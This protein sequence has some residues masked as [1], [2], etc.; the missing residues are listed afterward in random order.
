MFIKKS[1]VISI[2]TL[3]F[4]LIS[5]QAL[6]AESTGS[7]IFFSA[8]PLFLLVALTI[9]FRKKIFVET[10]IDSQEEN[11]Q[12]IT[13]QK[14]P[15]PV[16]KTTSAPKKSPTPAK[17]TTKPKETASTKQ[18]KAKSS[19][20]NND[21]SDDGQCQGSTA[22]GARCKRTTTLEKISFTIDDK[23]Y[24]LTACSQHK[25]DKFK[26]YPGLIK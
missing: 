24:Q 13:E 1:T 14:E 17:K 26:P 23:T 8:W 9:I 19:T 12:K 4:T 15:E 11:N 7:T 18:E 2:S 22:K 25:N 10:T 16:A 5:N 6:A 21:L 20:S 3:S